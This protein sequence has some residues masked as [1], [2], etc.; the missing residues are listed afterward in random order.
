MKSNLFHCTTETKGNCSNNRIPIF[1]MRIK[2]IEHLARFVAGIVNNES[3]VTHLVNI[4][5][6]YQLRISERSRH[7]SKT[8]P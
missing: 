7:Q 1:H 5:G 4:C 8:R 2:G 6:E 3:H